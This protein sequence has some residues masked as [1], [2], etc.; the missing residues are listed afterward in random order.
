LFDMSGNVMEWCQDFY[1]G[2]YYKKSPVENP[3]GPPQ[4]RTK[5]LRGDSYQSTN[6]STQR[7]TFRFQ[8]GPNHK[9]KNI[10][11]RLSASKN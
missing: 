11:F 8:Y 10:G 5:V 6:T 3:V 2:E 1:S 7:I 4:G 9:S